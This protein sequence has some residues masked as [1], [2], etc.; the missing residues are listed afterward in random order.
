[1]RASAHDNP[2][3][4]GRSRAAALLAPLAPATP[5]ATQRPSPPSANAQRPTPSGGSR[6]VVLPLAPATPLAAQ[7]PPPSRP[8]PRPAPCGRSRVV[9]LRLALLA[10]PARLLDLRLVQLLEAAR[11]ALMEGDGGAWVGQ[12]AGGPGVWERKGTGLRAPRGARARGRAGWRAGLT[13]HPQK[14]RPPS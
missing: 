9:V 7:R 2:T 1:M 4:C 11:V 12:R 14:Q 13:A 3:P 5:L 6:V 10:P 8:A